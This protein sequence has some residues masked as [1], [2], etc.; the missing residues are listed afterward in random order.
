VERIPL[1]SSDLVNVYL[2]GDVLID[3]GGRLA[4]RKLL[5]FL[6]GHQL[7]AHVLTHGHLDHQGCSHAVCEEFGIP[8]LCGEGDRHA[9]ESGDQRSLSPNPHSPMFRFMNLLAGPRHPVSATLSDGDEVGG[10]QV[11]ETPGHTPGHLAF[12]GAA[13]RVLILGDVLFHRNPATLRRGLAEPFRFATFDRAANLDA[14][15]KLAALQP[16]IICFGHGAPLTDGEL[17][18]RFVEGLPRL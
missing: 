12:W 15:R 5:R 13:S 11:I 3:S 7:A 6:R 4:R 2:A 9:V 14:A 10:F 17:F 18:Q 1:V 16:E 8:L